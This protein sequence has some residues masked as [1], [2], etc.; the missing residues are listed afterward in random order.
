MAS[1]CLRRAALPRLGF[2][3]AGLI[4]CGTAA[5][6]TTTASAAAPTSP[7]MANQASL[8]RL[9]LPSLEQTLGRYMAAIT[10]IVGKD[11]LERNR[12]AVEAALAPDSSLRELHAQLYASDESRDDLSY[13][14]TAWDEMYLAARCSVALN[15]NPGAVVRSKT[16]FDES[17]TSQI[18][19]AARMVV[20]NAAFA[21]RVESGALSPDV[22]RGVP[23]DM[24]Q[25]EG[26][27]GATRL[28]REGVDVL[29]K[30]PPSNSRHIVVLVRDSIWKLPIFDEASGSLLSVSSIEEALRE[31]CE[32]TAP[33]NGRASPS[34]AVLT[35]ADRDTWA[36]LRADLESHSPAN[37]SSL[38]AIDDALFAL[39]LDTAT[40]GTKGGDE[41]SGAQMVAAERLALC[42]DAYD[43][44]RWMD[45]S[46][47]LCVS[48]DGVPIIHFEHSW[49]DGICVA[50]AG[51][52]AWHT[53][54]TNAF[55]PTPAGETAAPPR[56]LEWSLP[57]AVSS[58]LPRVAADYESRCA[59]LEVDILTFERF[60]GAAIKK[61][62][63]SPDG[64]AQAAIALAFYS[65]NGRLA[66]T[67]E[68][69][70]TA[71]F[72][73]G[74][75]ET[76]RPVTSECQAWVEGAAAGAELHEQARLLR[77]SA[78]AHQR[79]A[80]EASEGHGFDR[81]LFALRRLAERRREA[82]GGSYAVPALF[83]EPAYVA[84]CANEMSTSSVSL[85]HTLNS[86]FGPV[87]PEGYGV[88]YFVG[89]RTSVPRGMRFC[90]TAY[91]PRS[92][93]KLNEAIEEAL[94]H[95]QSV[96][97][98]EEG[99]ARSKL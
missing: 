52:E 58:A 87:H 56:R 37:V 9:P 19:R 12:K 76:I 54:G 44:P 43:A 10:P 90:T 14:S 17:T 8:P 15:S 61:W 75:T 34:L 5:K 51:G 80:K 11:E 98:A 50:R 23:L 84:L 53:I 49:G 45:K 21:L 89:E 22:M 29:H 3:A 25:Y 47:S 27:Y 39:S 66:A 57:P 28:P 26:M 74:R 13:V 60:G 41:P 92:A 31:I 81:H 67:Y 78:K 6:R 24:R 59:A 35:T 72:A 1:T 99:A 85:S 36:R 55:P 91:A 93:R 30:A 82:S 38:G 79:V 88:F 95:V 18:A 7:M 86:G 69:A 83:S 63:V 20:A 97:E 70:T 94:V 64:I 33:P 32:Q 48:A 46:V 16:A 96:L 65:L 62:G 73:G 4:G 40:A 68:S 42:G 71:R 2:A 77:A